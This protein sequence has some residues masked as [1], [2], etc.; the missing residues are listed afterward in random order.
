MPSNAW[1]GSA[2]GARHC[3]LRDLRPACVLWAWL[4]LSLRNALQWVAA[5]LA[6]VGHSLLFAVGA[7]PPQ[8]GVRRARRL[9][10]SR[11]L[12]ASLPPVPDSQRD[13]LVHRPHGNDAAPPFQAET[14]MP[15]LM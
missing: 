9:N 14:G 6:P 8:D 10:L 2:L 1:H 5:S 12:K 3:S 13:H 15:P 7:G 11:D 4:W